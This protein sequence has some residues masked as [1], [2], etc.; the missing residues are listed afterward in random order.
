M[1]RFSINVYGS[2]GIDKTYSSNQITL[3][4][5]KEALA[6]EDKVEALK[7]KGLQTKAQE[8]LLTISSLIEPLIL[9]LFPTMTLEELE[10][11]ELKDVMHVYKQVCNYA[12]SG[13]L[14]KDITV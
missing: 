6:L 13:D 3:G 14:L 12:K 10:R 1:D 4:L 11:C 2:N 9:K 8:C 5:A 7:H